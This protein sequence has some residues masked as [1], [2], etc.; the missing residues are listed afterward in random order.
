MAVS[1]GEKFAISARNIRDNQAGQ[2]EDTLVVLF[3]GVQPQVAETQRVVGGQ[4]GR[5]ALC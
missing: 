2:R 1:A 5:I 4:M 3:F